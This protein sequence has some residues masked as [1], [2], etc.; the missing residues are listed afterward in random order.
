MYSNTFWPR[1]GTR[2]RR[3]VRAHAT[4][5]SPAVTT[6][7]TMRLEVML[8]WIS[9][10]SGL[11]FTGPPGARSMTTFGG[12]GSRFWRIVD[13]GF[14]KPSGAAT[15]RAIASTT[16]TARAA[17]HSIRRLEPRAACGPSVVAVP[18]VAGAVWS[19]NSLSKQ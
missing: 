14:G 3:R 7:D 6:H 11:L 15:I 18:L 2:L 19:D 8:G 5:I 12:T 17:S 16:R 4:R 13:F 9:T 1:L 10:T